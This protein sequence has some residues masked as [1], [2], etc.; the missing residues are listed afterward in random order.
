M[1]SDFLI[2][3]AEQ[4]RALLPARLAR[5]GSAAGADALVVAPR[6]DDPGHL[7]II[8]RRGGRETLAGAVRLDE[9]GAAPRPAAWGGRKRPGVIVLRI[10][11]ELLLE[12]A[13]E[14]PLAAERDLGRVMRYEMDRLTPFD[15]DEV[16]WHAAV[17]RRDR[18]RGRLHVRL[19]LVAIAAV[20]P[21]LAA[22]R[23]IGLAPAVLEAPAPGGGVRRIGLVPPD[24]R[25]A[26]SR[27]RLDVAAAAA[28]A[29]LALVAA[30][31]PFVRQSL[32]FAAI[33]AR[34]GQLQPR[35]AEVEALRR[36]IASQG[37][38]ADVLTAERARTGDVLQ[39]LASVTELLPDDT[40]L[41]DFTLSQGKLGIGG[42][43]SAAARLI[44]ALAGDPLIHDPAF[45]APVTRAE[46]GGLDRF[47]I[48]AELAH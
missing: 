32:A 36:H 21:A 26:R 38:G 10:G 28:C 17:E 39:V 48:R 16:F 2:W 34:I 15:I 12:R 43:S 7:D 4:M 35:V 22:L 45:I 29:A 11:A 9:A 33:E 3:W 40:V 23:D 1:L 31:L 8:L 44:P 25:R 5:I 6:A 20:A 24:D 41:S 46:E 37:A 30:G 18:A 19:S 42:T 27:H 47:A 13:I 14:L